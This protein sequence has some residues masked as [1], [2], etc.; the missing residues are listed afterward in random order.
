MRAAVFVL[1]LCAALCPAQNLLVNGDLELPAGG[2]PN[3]IDGWTLTEPSVDAMLNPANSA[4][5]VGF[6]NHT[7]GGERGLWLRPFAGGMGDGAPPTVDAILTQAVMGAA[8]TEYSLS[9]WFMYEANY[10]GLDAAVGTRTILAIDFLDGA[11]GVI[12][13]V[14]LDID[15]VQTGDSVWRQ[16][17]VMGVA[18]GGTAFVQARAGMYDGVF[19]AAN[20]QSAFVDDFFLIPSP[21]SITLLAGAGV[22]GSR[23]RRSR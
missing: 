2:G 7:P 5:F 12:S 4:D 21:A 19:A 20:P 18:P 10:S 3:D 17:E 14:E 15:T 16:F 23:R 9:A 1:P 11:M 6:A 22:L 8:G 13:S